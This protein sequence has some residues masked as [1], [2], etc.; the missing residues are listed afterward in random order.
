M[1]VDYYKSFA[2]S[3]AKALSGDGDV[4]IEDTDSVA[5]MLMGI[6]NFLGI[7]AMIEGMSDEQID[8]MMDRT[9]MP[10]LVNGILTQ[11]HSDGE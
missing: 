6:S 11:N 5:Y 4:T 8:E 7:K 2:R 9:V 3:Y 1:F 10:A